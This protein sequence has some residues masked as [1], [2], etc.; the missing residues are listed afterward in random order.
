[1]TARRDWKM[2][3][4]MFSG[5]CNTSAKSCRMQ[6][7]RGSA[8][9]TSWRRCSSSAVSHDGLS[10]LLALVWCCEQ[11]TRSRAAHMALLHRLL[12]DSAMTVVRLN[13]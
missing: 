2:T 3:W 4:S 13:H 5:R 9:Q 8:E 7:R 11:D 6:W 1:M 12:M 10:D